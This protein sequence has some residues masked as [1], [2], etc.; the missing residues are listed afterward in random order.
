MVWLKSSQTKKRSRYP[1]YAPLRGPPG[2]GLVT[3]FALQAFCTLASKSPP[4]P[5]VNG[6]GPGPGKT[7]PAF[8]QPGRANAQGGAACL[9]AIATL[10]LR[11]A[12]QARPTRFAARLAAFVQPASAAYHLP[13]GKQAKR[14]ARQPTLFLAATPTR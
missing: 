1:F 11:K 3:L 8:P 12:T 4:S 5:C 14:P 2:F 9:R 10:K 7:G 13:V 6:L